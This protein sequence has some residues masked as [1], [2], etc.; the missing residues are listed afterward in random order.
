MGVRTE[1]D[2]SGRWI[3]AVI[4]IPVMSIIVW[5]IVVGQL[6]L[7]LIFLANGFVLYLAWR[8]VRAVERIAREFERRGRRAPGSG[9]LEP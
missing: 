4:A 3:V 5:S 6:L 8:F 1:E 9:G 7:G 2:V